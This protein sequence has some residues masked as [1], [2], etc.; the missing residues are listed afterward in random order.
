MRAIIGLVVSIII[1]SLLLHNKVPA[2][3][4]A[5]SKIRAN[6][7][8]DILDELNTKADLCEW[9]SYAKATCNIKQGDYQD[10]LTTLESFDIEASQNKQA[11]HYLF[12]I[13]HLNLNNTDAFYASAEASLNSGLSPLTYKNH[14]FDSIRNEAR[15]IELLDSSG[16][17]MS[18]WII[19]FIYFTLQSIL[20]AIIF[21]TRYKSNKPANILLGLFNLAIAITLANYIAYWSEAMLYEKLSVFI[22]LYIPLCYVFGPLLYFYVKHL[23]KHEN[24]KYLHYHLIP[25]YLCLTIIL[26]NQFGVS[27]T[28]FDAVM[29]G[30][31]NLWTRIGYFIIYSI[32]LIHLYNTSK[33]E[34]NKTIKDWLFYLTIA[35]V[36]FTFSYIIYGVLLN[37]SFFNQRWDYMISLAICFFIILIS[38]FGYLQP[39]I[40]KG[41]NIKEAI[42]ANIK[43]EKSSLS[44]S[45]KIELKSKLADLMEKEKVYK[46][47]EITLGKLSK[48]LDT[49][50]HNTSQ[51]INEQFH[52][53]FY[54]FIN[55]YRV[56]EAKS[57]LKQNSSQVMNINEILFEVGF[58]N[59]VTFNKAFKK[60]TGMPP[61]H[62]RKSFNYS[63]T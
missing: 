58:N 22:R 24:I 9:E 23:L 10:A 1:I 41:I 13:C 47:N 27:N 44:E 16:T 45:F 4:N 17:R 33:I 53:N 39:K 46:D 21:F 8:D 28:Y 49:T 61:S 26:L 34:L 38:V 5:Y 19:L 2:Y 12:S 6:Q 29:Y 63:N 35:F 18:G 57:L 11:L 51:I 52:E 56:E 15:F 7:C 3:Y 30:F 48:M 54:E 59:K 42:I 40:F 60:R 31:F 14:H 25:A 20:L 50:T 32:L 43:Y 36:C 37:F 62:F 55:D